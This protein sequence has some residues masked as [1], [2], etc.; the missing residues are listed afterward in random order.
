MDFS[1]D[2]DKYNSWQ[3]NKLRMSFPSQN[4]CLLPLLYPLGDALGG[5]LEVTLSELLDDS[6]EELL[7]ELD[8]DFVVLDR[9]LCAAGA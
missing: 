8:D 1:F 7:E 4:Y 5:T 9:L 3:V 2:M 6:L